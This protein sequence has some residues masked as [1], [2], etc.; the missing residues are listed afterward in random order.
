MS[1]ITVD[2]NQ[3]ISI[4]I[5]S[6]PVIHQ[7]HW[8]FIEIGITDDWSTVHSLVI[9]QVD[10]QPPNEYNYCLWISVNDN[11][12]LCMSLS[13]TRVMLICDPASV[14][15]PI[16]I[17]SLAQGIVFS[18]DRRAHQ[19]LCHSVGVAVRGWAAILKVA[20][21]FRPHLQHKA[22]ITPADLAVCTYATVTSSVNLIKVIMINKII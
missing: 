17:T 9:P 11:G 1:V 14:R 3:A 15:L 21:A 22:D 4:H 10:C 18:Q 2:R 12:P 16:L 6:W 8:F 5:N 19:D 7:V 20:L 13:L